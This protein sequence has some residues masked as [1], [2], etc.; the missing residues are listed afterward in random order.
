MSDKHQRQPCSHQERLYKLAFEMA[1]DRLDMLG[2][3]RHHR[4]TCDLKIDCLDCL[5][6]YYIKKAEEEMK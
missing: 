3:C 2:A 5:K 6:D 4:K 1:V